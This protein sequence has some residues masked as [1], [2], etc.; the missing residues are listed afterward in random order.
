VAAYQATVDLIARM[1]LPEG[2]EDFHTLSWLEYGN[3]MLGKFDEA[4][5]NVDL[6]RQA[7]D[8]NPRN[9]NI[10]QQY[11]TMLARYILETG[12]WER[13]PLEGTTDA[14]AGH[15]TMPGM[16]GG[17]AGYSGRATWIF[18]AGLSAAKLGDP[19]RAEQARAKL[20]GMRQ[21]VES[22]GDAYAAKPLAIM[23]N[24]VAAAVALARGRKSEAVRLAKQA[25]DIEA[26][27][28]APS[29][30][31]DPIKPALE[32]YAEVLL[33]AGRPAEAATAFEQELLRTP[34]R[35]PSVEGLAR[36]AAQGGDPAAAAK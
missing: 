22:A 3:L 18:I 13:I 19:E 6:A 35:T 9:P 1:H 24:E 12:K 25:V 20:G 15:E 7:A 26:T 34:K 5:K 23:E 17:S 32:L 31:P 36:S 2:R 10:A 28:A 8:R 4:R 27:L 16:P 14:P 11:H 21:D 29:G 33:D 30:P